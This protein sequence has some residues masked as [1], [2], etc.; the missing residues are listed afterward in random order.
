M[1]SY[2][3]GEEYG[4]YAKPGFGADTILYHANTE[5]ARRMDRYVPMHHWAL[6]HHCDTGMPA[7]K[8]TL[9]CE[10][11]ELISCAGARWKRCLYVHNYSACPR[12]GPKFN[13]RGSH[14]SRQGV[15]IEVA[16]SLAR[17]VNA[18]HECGP[19]LS[20]PRTAE[21]RAAAPRCVR[22]VRP[23][24]WLG[25]VGGQCPSNCNGWVA[26]SVDW[27]SYSISEECSVAKLRSTHNGQTM[28]CAWSMHTFAWCGGRVTVSSSPRPAQP[29]VSGVSC[30]VSGEYAK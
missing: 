16:S 21:A 28:V 24:S 1:G 14:S 4:I 19:L 9:R 29:Q 12:T 23:G 27:S 13:A 6:R 3:A 8:A 7:R 10:Q 20:R 25:V 26:F 18:W 5:S 17:R 30:Q 2:V 15:R 22:P 11:R